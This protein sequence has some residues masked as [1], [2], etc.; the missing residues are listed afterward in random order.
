MFK[1]FLKVCLHLLTVVAWIK[2]KSC[3]KCL[4]ILVAAMHFKDWNWISKA[5][6]DSKKIFF[7][8]PH[9]LKYVKY[10]LKMMSN[11]QMLL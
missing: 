6:M 5:I 8:L 9:P 7:R 11:H 1:N 4:L 3:S 10:F 2:M